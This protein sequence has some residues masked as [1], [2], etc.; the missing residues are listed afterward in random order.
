MSFFGFCVLSAACWASDS[1]EDIDGKKLREHYFDVYKGVL[2][3]NKTPQEKMIE[4]LEG[5]IKKL[6]QESSKEKKEEIIKEIALLLR[7]KVF[8]LA[9]KSTKKEKEALQNALKS[10]R[11][12]LLESKIYFDKNNPHENEIIKI[13]TINSKEMVADLLELEEAFGGL[14]DAFEKSIKTIPPNLRNEIFEDIG[15]ILAIMRGIFLE[16][17]NIFE[18][19]QKIDEETQEKIYARHTKI[20]NITIEIDQT[21]QGIILKKNISPKSQK[22]IASIKEQLNNQKSELNLII[23]NQKTCQNLQEISNKIRALGKENPEGE[24]L[25]SIEEVISKQ[26]EFMK[27]LKPKN[28][29]AIQKALDALN[30][31]CKEFFGVLAHIPAILN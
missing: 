5:E 25:K 28:I 30:S 22:E 6:N 15:N 23:E 13:L 14:C 12:S 19:F 10:N 21:I 20:N 27:N 17:E 2:S 31:Y 24:S 18:Y 16:Y 11:R 9:K 7:G 1:Q 3:S 29:P 26:S 8:P 4:L